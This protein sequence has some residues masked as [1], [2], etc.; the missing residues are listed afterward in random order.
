MSKLNFSKETIDVLKKVYEVNQGIKLVKGGD[1]IKCKSTD[2]SILIH[3]PIKEDIPRD[4][5]IYDLREFLSVLS[6]IEDPI[7]DF[8]NDKYLQIQSNDETQK[9]R[10]LES[11]P[12]FVK[13]YIEKT[14][15]L[16]SIDFSVTVTGEQ[17]ASVMKAA[18][19]MKLE[20]VG[21]VSDGEKIDIAAFNKNNGDDSVTNNFSIKLIEEETE[22]FEMFFKIETMNVGV[23]LGEGDLNFDVCSKKITKIVTESGKTFWMAMNTDSKWGV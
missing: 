21:F 10:Y 23:L 3:A 8:S 9:L 13:S 11:D 19:L 18:T 5:H 2:G 6:I 7:I 17:F 12:E 15:N 16:P 14:P 20:Y 1:T 4:F 22:P